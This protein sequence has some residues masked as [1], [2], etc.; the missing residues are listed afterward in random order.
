MLSYGFNEFVRS[1]NPQIE[2]NEHVS[3]PA[4]NSDSN[5]ELA[6]SESLVDDYRLHFL[7]L[8]KSQTPTESEKITPSHMK[9]IIA[10]SKLFPIFSEVQKYQLR[11]SLRLRSRL[12]KFFV[13]GDRFRYYVPIIRIQAEI[14]FFSFSV[15]LEKSSKV[16]IERLNVHF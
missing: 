12:E 10:S 13:C 3:P 5:Y 16:F 9:N 1:R 8:I 14:F 2:I 11:H 15:W 4:S 7:L 6:K